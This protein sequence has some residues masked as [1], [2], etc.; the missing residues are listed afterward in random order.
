MKDRKRKEKERERKRKKKSERKKERRK[1]R[2][3]LEG[4]TF[5]NKGASNSHPFSRTTFGETK[6]KEKEK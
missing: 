6:V 4:E 1:A 5:F 2:N 3:R